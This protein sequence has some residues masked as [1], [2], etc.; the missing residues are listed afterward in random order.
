MCVYY[1]MHM[2]C[3]IKGKHDSF[4][5]ARVS[6]LETFHVFEYAYISCDI[7]SMKLPLHFYIHVQFCELSPA[8]WNFEAFKV[9]FL[10]HV[11]VWVKYNPAID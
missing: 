8:M 9:T 4:K 2:F 10:F 5:S 7:K 3:A 11:N 6:I 1:R